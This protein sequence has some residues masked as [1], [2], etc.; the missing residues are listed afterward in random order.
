LNE[1]NP[2]PGFTATSLYPQIAL[3]HGMR[4]DELIQTLLLLGM[5]RARQEKRKGL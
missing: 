3:Q 5:E 4:S 2:I 1:I